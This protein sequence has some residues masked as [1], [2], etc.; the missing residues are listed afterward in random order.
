MK[1]LRVLLM[2]TAVLSSAATV[3]AQNPYLPPVAVAVPQQPECPAQCWFMQALQDAAARWQRLQAVCTSGQETPGCAKGAG[4][5]LGVIGAVKCCEAAQGPKCACAKECA[6]CEACKAKNAAAQ[7]A[8]AAVPGLP[9]S[10]MPCIGVGAAPMMPAFLR[11]VHIQMAPQ[12]KL[13][14][15]VTPDL[16]A[17]CQRI[18]HQGDM[19]VLEGNVLLLCK[20]HAQPI[21]IEAQ[22]IIVNM[23]DGSFSVESDIRPM[24]ASAFGVL[25]TSAVTAP[26]PI[27]LDFGFPTVRT[28]TT[29][30]SC[31]APIHPSN[32]QILRD[33]YRLRDEGRAL[34]TLPVAQPELPHPV[35]TPADIEAWF[36]ALMEPMH[37]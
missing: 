7:A 35:P 12:T 3:Q 33:A 25:R 30:P 31:V 28:H 11:V 36:R 13:V 5:V 15:L 6:C 27:S 37:R 18:H 2:L 1:S 23:K 32:E 4:C 22:R 29:L 24:P 8:P 14:H 9:C 17:H 26:T 21:R 19:V 20:K 34:P 10:G 16:E